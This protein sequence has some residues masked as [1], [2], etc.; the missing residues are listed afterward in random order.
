MLN[1]FLHDELDEG[2]GV[3]VDREG[4]HGPIELFQTGPGPIL[5][6]H[7]FLPVLESLD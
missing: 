2:Q 1:I 5:L 7:F 6:S 3:K 4:I